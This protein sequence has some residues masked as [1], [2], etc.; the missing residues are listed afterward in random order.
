MIWKRFITFIVCLAFLLIPFEEANAD[1]PP[2]PE[3]PI[4]AQCLIAA[5]VI[6]VGVVILIGLA[7]MCKCLPPNNCSTNKIDHASNAILLPPLVAAGESEPGKTI[8]IQSGSNPAGEWAEEFSFQFRN[9]PNGL[10]AVALRFGV[11]ILTNSTPALSSTNGMA[12]VTYDFTALSQYTT[13]NT[14]FR[15]HTP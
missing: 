7:K 6:G 11:P 9:G 10:E 12:M 4:I 15:L 3:E 14:F 2:P 8:V 5:L 1:V 13:P